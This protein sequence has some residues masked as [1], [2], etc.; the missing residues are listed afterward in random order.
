MRAVVLLPLAGCMPAAYVVTQV[1]P[2]D[3]LPATE[4]DI[5]TLERQT[6]GVE[7]EISGLP[8][9]A[10]VGDERDARCASFTA[11]DLRSL[12]VDAWGSDDVDGEVVANPRE[13]VFTYTHAAQ[14]EGADGPA[15]GE[16]RDCTGTL[17]AEP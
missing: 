9:M 6:I 2:A 15:Y 4:G 17:R 8:S 14:I 16:P 10:C 3:C 1:E 12:S 13:L 11:W 5:V 7:L